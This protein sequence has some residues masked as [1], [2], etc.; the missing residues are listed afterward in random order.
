MWKSVVV[1]WIKVRSLSFE[2]NDTAGCFQ[3]LLQFFGLFC[4]HVFLEHR[5]RLICEILGFFESQIEH[6]SQGLDDLDLLGHIQTGQFD[7]V[8]FLNHL[9][10]FYLSQ[11]LLLFGEDEVQKFG[12]LPLGFDPLLLVEVRDGV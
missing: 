11:L 7:I 4:L 6:L 1:R 10:L 12:L 2:S 3:V 9:D 5:G 8:A